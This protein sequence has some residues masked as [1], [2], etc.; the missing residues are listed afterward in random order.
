[1]APSSCLVNDNLPRASVSSLYWTQIG[2]GVAGEWIPA[3]SW[4]QTQD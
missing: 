3:Q 2:Y 4:R 1:M